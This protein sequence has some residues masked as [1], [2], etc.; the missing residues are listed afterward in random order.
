MTTIPINEEHL[1]ARQVEVNNKLL[2]FKQTLSENK[3]QAMTMIQN[4]AAFCKE[5]D[6]PIV[7]FAK[8]YKKGFH[9][10]NSFKDEDN[11][12]NEFTRAYMKKSWDNL[13]CFVYGVIDFIVPSYIV[14][15]KMYSRVNGRLILD[16][17]PPKDN[18]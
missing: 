15:I 9:Q 4:T 3:A 12:E 17:H 11:H 18:D 8:F 13:A 14:R 2:E 5:N 16:T 10:W 6:V 7:V 1:E